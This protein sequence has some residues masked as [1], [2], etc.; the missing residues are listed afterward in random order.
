MHRQHIDL[1]EAIQILKDTLPLPETE[2]LLLEQAA[3]RVLAV[4]LLARVDHPSVDDSAMDGIACKLSDSQKTP[5]T[6]KLVGESR[7]GEGF[8]GVVNTGECI[9]IYTGAPVPEGAD[10]I[11]KVEDLHIEGDQVTLLHPARSQDIRHR[12]SDFRAGQEGLQKGDVLSPARLALCASMGHRTV[13]VFRKLRVGILSTGDEIIEAGEPL[14][15]GQVY[16]SNKYGIYAQLLDL[17]L[18]PVLLPHAADHPEKVKEN[19]KGAGLDVLLTSGGVSMGNYDI[20][21]DLLF[22]EGEVRFWKVNL[23]PGGPALCGLWEGLPVLGLPGNPVSALVVFEVLFKPAVFALLGRTDPAH[24]K[25]RAR[26]L[27][28]F[29]AVPK[30]TA[31]WRAKLV[32]EDGELQVQDGNA[33]LS[34]MLRGLAHANALVVVQPGKAIEAGELAEVLWL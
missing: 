4:P 19:L 33:P 27:N 15:A 14:A 29:K 10:A 8:S 28:P 6:L 7:A 3:G 9:R 17:G 1:D 34:N 30:K 11:C 21:R 2:I 31:Y 23:R 12:G 26:A 18:E 22:N 5:V 24:R 13:E 25:V 32:F 20:V 16:D